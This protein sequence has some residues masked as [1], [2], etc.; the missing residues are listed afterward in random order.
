[1]IWILE[2]S[3]PLIL[4][5]NV[6]V[7]ER[8][9]GPTVLFIYLRV[10]E[11]GF[12]GPSKSNEMCHSTGPVIG[13]LLLRFGPEKFKLVCHWLESH[14]LSGYVWWFEFKFQTVTGSVFDS[15]ILHAIRTNFKFRIIIKY[16]V[17]Q[18]F[19]IHHLLFLLL[20][21]SL[22]VVYIIIYNSNYNC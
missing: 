9:V 3:W 10:S 12:W 4:L 1:M 13:I 21:Y 16:W 5:E 6:N 20:T 18:G 15:F 22:T 14:R 7:R 8:L 19:H 2:R 17:H 11:S